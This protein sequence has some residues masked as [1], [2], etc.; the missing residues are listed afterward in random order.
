MALRPPLNP[1]AYFFVCRESATPYLTPPHGVGSTIPMET[2][3]ECAWAGCRKRFEP[4]RQANSRTTYCSPTCRKR[5]HRARHMIVTNGIAGPSVQDDRDTAPAPPSARPG[6]ASFVLP[7]SYVLSDWAP[8]WQPHWPSDDD[9][10]S[11]S[12]FL[13]R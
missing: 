5:A 4:G 1:T 8:S 7:E 3:K 10:L 9:D 12:D 11:I 13:K 6:R 2:W